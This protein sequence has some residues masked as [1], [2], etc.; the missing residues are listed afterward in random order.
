M[1]Q[2]EIPITQYVYEIAKQTHDSMNRL[3][4]KLD[5]NT[6]ITSK[7]LLQATKTNGRVNALEDKVNDYPAI[8]AKVWWI[9]GI[10]ST[11]VVTGGVIY[12]LVI[13]NIANT[14]DQ[15]FNQCC[16]VAPK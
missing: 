15:K 2:D 6:D 1:T 14:I 5:E 7:V 4:K 8:K 11:V 16:Y 9:I 10:G 13:S 12:T 3:E